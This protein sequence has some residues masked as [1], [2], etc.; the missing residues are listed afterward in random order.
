MSDDDQRT[1]ASGAP[2]EGAPRPHDERHTGTDAE[3][4]HADE[5]PSAPPAQPAWTSSRDPAGAPAH[6]RPVPDPGM[7]AGRTPG[8]SATTA[9]SAT[10][11]GG[12]ANGA[13]RSEGAGATSVLPTAPGRVRERGGVPPRP[14]T[15]GGDA[16]TGATR[17]GARPAGRP[18]RARL[19]VQ[20]VDPWSVFLFS[21]VASICLGVVLLVAV[22][23]LFLVLTSLGVVSSVNSV[24]G[25]VLGGGAPDDVIEPYITAGRVLGGT[26]VLAAVDVVLLTA[27]A[28]LGAL[29]YNLCA[30]LTGGLEVVLG[31]RD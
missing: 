18:R 2:V 8:Y 26:A 7:A 21:L 5:M 1:A 31:E 17:V 16:R 30:S 25:E 23:A 15:G 12:A 11:G 24:L 14:S 19:V 27:L 3:H 22:T 28:T 4:A 20:R 10:A 13:A 6:A 9:A 29:L